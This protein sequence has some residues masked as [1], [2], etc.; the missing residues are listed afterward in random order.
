MP[1]PGSGLRLRDLENFRESYVHTLESWVRN[2]EANHDKV[3]NLV[4]EA[5]YRVF[6]IYMAGATLGFKNGVYTLNQLLLAKPQ[7]GATHLPLTRTDWW[8]TRLT[9]T[10]LGVARVKCVR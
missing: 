10:G 7:D 2:L 4:G 6:R 5:S 1:R 8:R 3:V 9:A